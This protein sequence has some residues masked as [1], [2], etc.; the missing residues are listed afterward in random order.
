M[1]EAP[2][3]RAWT[4]AHAMFP[5]LLTPSRASIILGI[6][7]KRIERLAER[8]ELSGI[9]VDGEIRFREADLFEFLDRAPRPH[10]AEPLAG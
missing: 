5:E 9:L 1:V 7:V 2:F 4:G 10:V 8:G 6:R 3:V